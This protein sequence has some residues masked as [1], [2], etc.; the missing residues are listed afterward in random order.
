MDSNGRVSNFVS[1]LLG[2]GVIALVVIGLGLGGAFDGGGDAA[3]DGG[4]NTASS[5]APAR[6]VTDV[7]DLFER[8][9]EGVVYVQ[10]G[11]E[12]EQVGSQP[13]PEGP[14]ENPLEDLLP[15][16]R[17]GP[18]EDQ[19]PGPSEPRG[20]GSGFVLDEEGFILTNQHVVGDA[21]EV[22]VR[23]GDADG[24]TPARVMG[25]DPGSDLALLKVNPDDLEQELDPLELGS[26]GDAEVG[27]PAIAIGS[28]FGLTGSLTTGVIS[29]LDRPI[30]APNGF[31]ID[32]A[33]QTDAAIN[34]GNSGGPLLD[35]SGRVIGINAQIA[36][37]TQSNSGVGFA[38]PVDTA[39]DVIPQLREGEEIERAY[40]GVSSGDAPQGGALVAEVRPG[41]PADQGGIEVGDRI[42]SVDGQEV[43]ESADVSALVTAKRPGDKVEITVQRG[44]EEESLNVELGE[45]PED[46][47]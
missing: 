4:E 14:P 32:G 23:I 30:R 6:N 40:L 24:L 17:P 25:T 34:P 5:G 8:V 43:N 29:A 15:D 39:K 44:G 28:P 7:S 2:A 33:L 31:T 37:G 3:G 42:V 12:P 19:P 20:S 1:A 26:S 41:D 36:T 27:N 10:V 16:P 13:E 18:R 11:S 9:R 45:R 35:A 46:A 38:I 22:Q 47:G 21:R